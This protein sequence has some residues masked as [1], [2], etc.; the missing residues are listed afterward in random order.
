ME[1]NKDERRGEDRVRRDVVQAVLPV[2]IPFAAWFILETLIG[3]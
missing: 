2:G 1:N 3:K